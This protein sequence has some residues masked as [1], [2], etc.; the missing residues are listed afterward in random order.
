MSYLVGGVAFS[1][2]GALNS[3]LRS[4]CRWRRGATVGVSGSAGREQRAMVCRPRDGHFSRG[5]YL[6]WAS[7][8]ALG[9]AK[10]KMT[11]NKNASFPARLR[12]R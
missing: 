12:L 2:A 5:K 1:T 10:K 11:D 6:A 7:I 4:V 9:I 8:Q 3:H